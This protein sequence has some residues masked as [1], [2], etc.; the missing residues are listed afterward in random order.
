M[1][2][3]EAYPVTFDSENTSFRFKSIGKRGVFDKVVFFTPLSPDT[4]NLAL[5]DYEPA[6]KDYN[7]R[8]VTDNGDMT[9]VIAT[10][11]SIIQ[12]FLASN[13]DQKIYFEGNSPARTRLYQIAISKVYIPDN[14]DL[15]IKGYRGDQWVSFEPNINF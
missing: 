15:M 7:D 9:E 1:Q 2:Q 10:V 4:H 6:T 11:I 13:P 5:V 12:E 3:Y 14:S 8:S